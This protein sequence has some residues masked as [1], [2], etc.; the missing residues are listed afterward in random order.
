M[1]ELEFATGDTSTKW[2]A[3]RAKLGHPAP[4]PI[5]YVE[6]GNEDEFD[7][8]GSYEGR[9]AQFSKAIKAK[10]PEAAVDRHDAAEAHAA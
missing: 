1:D 6:I 3:V 2:G 7:T 9:Y 8:S 4:F 10:Y 5:N